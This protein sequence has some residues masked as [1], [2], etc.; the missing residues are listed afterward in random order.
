MI[1]GQGEVC[2]LRSAQES[3]LLTLASGC[4]Y[5]KAEEGWLEDSSITAGES[6]KLGVELEEKESWRR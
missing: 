5:P 4:L 6:R 2:L 1:G 3:P